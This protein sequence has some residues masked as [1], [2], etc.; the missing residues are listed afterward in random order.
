[1]KA[2][3]NPV[4]QHKVSI[5]IEIP[6]EEV[7]KGFTQA[8]K[9]IAGQVNIPGFRKGKAPRKILEMNYGKEAIAEEAFEILAGRAYTQALRDNEIIPVSE[10][11]IEREQFEEGKDLIFKATLVK[12]PE[13]TLGDY[14]GLEV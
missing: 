4:D 6:A 13:V 12:Q 5:T 11:E 7:N 3:V 8:V 14:K 1:M 9:R 10:P 2:T